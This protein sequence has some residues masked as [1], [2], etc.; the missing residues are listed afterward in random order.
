MIELKDEEERDSRNNSKMKEVDG[1]NEIVSR[2]EE[3]VEPALSKGILYL[4]P[5]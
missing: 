3:Q 5:L 4:Y 1:E 2:E